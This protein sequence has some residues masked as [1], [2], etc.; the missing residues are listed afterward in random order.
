MEEEEYALAGFS[1]DDFIKRFGNPENI[2]F[3]EFL[4]LQANYFAFS[5]QFRDQQLLL[6]S[7]QDAKDFIQKYPNSNYIPIVGSMLLRLELS[8]LVF[9]KEIAKLYARKGKSSGAEYYREKTDNSTW[10]KDIL[11]ENAKSPWYHKLFEW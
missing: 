10:L 7:I 9:N 3:A 6:D 4:K 5:K 2:D 11:H 1:Y 8:N